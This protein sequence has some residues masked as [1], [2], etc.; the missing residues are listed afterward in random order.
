MFQ[1]ALNGLGSR[2]LG[3]KRALL[4]SL[5]APVG[6]LEYPDVTFRGKGFMYGWG[7]APKKP[8]GLGLPFVSH[9][10]FEGSL[11]HGHASGCR[12]GRY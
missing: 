12:C 7:S 10:L 8:C 2:P 4:L 5:K 11:I 9:E 3:R 1:A 6:Q